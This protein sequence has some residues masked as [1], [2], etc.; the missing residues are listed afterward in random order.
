MSRP[1]IVIDTNVLV[2]AAIQPRGLPARLLESV[3]VRAVE[4]C[5][6]EEILAEYSEVLGRAK[7]AG[8]DRHRVAR[9]LAVIAAEATLFRPADRLTVSPDESDNRFYECAAAAR[10]DYIVTG[11]ALHF[12]KPH[13]ATRI[14]T[15]RQL[16]TLLAPGEE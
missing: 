8:L 14:V 2:S 15:A 10:A 13:G 12:N 16:L 6:S 1:R 4:M 5:L 3:A 7:F 9:L 11:K